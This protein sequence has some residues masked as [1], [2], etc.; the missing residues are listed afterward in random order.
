MLGRTSGSE[1]ENV[2][3]EDDWILARRGI[4]LVLNNKYKEA[5]ALFKNKRDSIQLAAGHSYVVFMNA[6]MTFEED[7]LEEAMVVLKELEGKCAQNL[8]WIR[9]MK[10]RVFGKSELGV[11]ETLEQQIT[12]AD[13]QVCIAFLNFMTQDSTAGYVK[14]G[15]ALRKAWGLY[16]TAYNELSSQY[17]KV[18]GLQSQLPGESPSWRVIAS[19]SNTPS[20]TPVSPM[21]PTSAA[22]NQ[23][24]PQCNG[25]R[26]HFYRL[27][28]PLP[29]PQICPEEVQ[30]LMCAVSFGYGLFHLCVSLLPATIL[31]LIHIL[32]F[33]G[34]RTVGLEALMFAR[35]GPDMRAPLAIL[36]LLWYHTIMRPLLALN[37]QIISSGIVAADALVDE[38]KAEFGES[39]LFLF[40]R[41]RIHRLKN[42][43]DHAVRTYREAVDKS[44]QR[45]L[46]LLCLHEMG[47]CR[48]IQLDYKQAFTAFFQIKEQ[49]RWSKDFY[50]YLSAVCAGSLGEITVVAH[51]AHNLLKKPEVLKSQLDLMIARRAKLLLPTKTAAYYRCLVY[52][53]LYLWNSLPPS[54]GLLTILKD[55]ED[56]HRGD[57]E[58]MIGLK[59]L[60]N[61]VCHSQLGMTAAA[62]DILH[63]VSSQRKL[64]E[65]DETK[66]NDSHIPAN[67]LYEQ[68]VIL[69]RNPETCDEGRKLLESA[70]NDFNGYD[71]ENRLKLKIHAAMKE[72]LALSP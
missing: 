15:W 10:N 68:A 40:F 60:I 23:S 18:F 6:V 66:A 24:E 27:F 26:R 44:V 20:T 35:Q 63:L 71:F 70:Q 36:A 41:G 5:E 69:I 30:R 13:C 34:D 54:A 67:A 48:L 11:Y 47:W 55:C 50:T 53:M 62:V 4:Q 16:H 19:T 9:A 38:S 12:L 51:L 29:S 17:R 45:E 21:S 64:A 61:G 1:D 32:G 39:A 8:G 3:G 14:G 7:S 56:V 42:E 43:L 72:V 22:W 65:V 59:N 2:R 49:S 33:V 31:R 37:S 57:E 25:Y 58:P 28:S 52:E 46:S